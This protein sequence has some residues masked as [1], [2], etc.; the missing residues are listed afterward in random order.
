M[1]PDRAVVTTLPMQIVV[2][3]IAVLLWLG[4]I[5]AS[6][7]P[8]AVFS[9]HDELMDA[10]ARERGTY[11]DRAN[12]ARAVELMRRVRRAPYAGCRCEHGQW[13]ACACAQ[14][15]TLAACSFKIAGQT[16]SSPGIVR[17]MVCTLN[18]SYSLFALSLV[19]SIY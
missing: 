16:I 10:L 15:Y 6:T 1:G 18:G 8:S 11:V 12:K 19:C 5:W 17:D 9:S 7:L 14:P 4:P 2:C 13:T 3:S